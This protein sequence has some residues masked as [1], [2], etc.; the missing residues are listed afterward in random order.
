MIIL[1]EEHF[2]TLIDGLHERNDRYTLF[3][4]KTAPE[5][6]NYVGWAICVQTEHTIARLKY[7]YPDRAKAFAKLDALLPDTP[8]TILI[9]TETA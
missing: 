9:K 4:H 3:L 6:L 5:G 1:L 7:I 2:K 8:A